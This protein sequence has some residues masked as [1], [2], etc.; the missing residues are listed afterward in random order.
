MKTR[1]QLESGEFHEGAGDD[2]GDKETRELQV[3]L[4]GW[5]ERADVVSYFPDNGSLVDLTEKR[6]AV[7]A[8]E[9]K[10]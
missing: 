1:K 4:D 9:A 10:P 5:C 8:E 3:F 2:I 6:A 7:I